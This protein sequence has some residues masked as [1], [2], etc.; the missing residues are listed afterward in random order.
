MQLSGARFRPRTG[1]TIQVND[2]ETAMVDGRGRS[3]PISRSGDAVTCGN[4]TLDLESSS[5]TFLQWSPAGGDRRGTRVLLWERSSPKGGVCGEPRVIG[6]RPCSTR[7]FGVMNRATRSGLGRVQAPGGARKYAPVQAPGGARRTR[8]CAGAGRGGEYATVQS[9]GAAGYA[10][11][12]RLKTGILPR[13]SQSA[14][15]F[16]GRRW[17]DDRTT[18]CVH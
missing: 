10:Q 9:R 6:L 14:A 16:V 2:T 11:V 7:S 5:E 17:V 1:D 4:Y 18:N 12:C 3:W 15:G 8:S 13:R